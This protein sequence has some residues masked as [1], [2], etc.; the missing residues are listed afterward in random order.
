VMLRFRFSTSLVIKLLHIEPF[1][2]PPWHQSEQMMSTVLHC[3]LRCY[4]ARCILKIDR[5]CCC[6]AI[7]FR[8][9]L[10]RAVP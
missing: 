6:C 2:L 8:G 10:C 4:L 7:V 1:V 5:S 9:M 3:R